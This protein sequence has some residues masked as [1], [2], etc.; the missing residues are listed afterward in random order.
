MKDEIKFLII[1][2]L[3]IAGMFSFLSPI[4]TSMLPAEDNVMID[5]DDV[6]SYNIINE[7]E[8]EIV[9]EDNIYIIDLGFSDDVVDFTV[10]SN[11]H[12]ELE[13]FDTRL[14]WW[15]FIISSEPVYPDEYKIGRIIKTPS[16]D[17]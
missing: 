3:V 5:G 12:I 14:F 9:T 10:N 2:I 7:D 13:R 1:I 16:E 17:R 6:V 4:F 8:I 15:D 11:I